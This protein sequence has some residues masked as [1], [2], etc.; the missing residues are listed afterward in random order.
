MQVAKKYQES[1]KSLLSE[2]FKMFDENYKGF[3]DDFDTLII[4]YY[5]TKDKIE[6]NYLYI[7]NDELRDAIKSTIDRHSKPHG[8]IF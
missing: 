7:Q 5:S 3:S 4:N 8:Y 1:V 2:S 6:M